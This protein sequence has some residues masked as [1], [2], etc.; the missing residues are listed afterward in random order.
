MG[1]LKRGFGLLHGWSSAICYD[2]LSE[3]ADL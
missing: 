2:L 3:Q 1:K